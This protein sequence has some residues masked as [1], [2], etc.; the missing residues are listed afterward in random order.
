MAAHRYWRISVSATGDNSG[1]C[2]AEMQLRTT[3]GG[4]TVTGSGTASASSTYSTFVPSQAFDGNTNTAWASFGGPPQSLEYDF[5]VGNAYAIVEVS[6][7]GLSGYT[8]TQAPTAFTID[9]SDNGSSWYSSDGITTSWASEGETQVFDLTWTGSVSVSV[10][11]SV[12]I[13]ESVV[14]ASWT[15]LSINVKE[16][17][18]LVESLSEH[19]SILYQYGAAW[20][21]ALNPGLTFRAVNG[22]LGTFSIAITPPVLSLGGYQQAVLAAQLPGLTFTGVIKDKGSWAIKALIPLLEFVGVVQE[23]NAAPLE[24]A[25]VLAG[26]SFQGHVDLN[27][28]LSIAAEMARLTFAGNI[29]SGFTN[30]TLRY[31]RWI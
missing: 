5:G 23:G 2:I 27:G 18:S 9:Y 20:L 4:G 26:L 14:A 10:V 28:Q 31:Q 12:S 1:V 21:T 13:S 11:D 29:P 22:V 3:I 25:A 16:L 7:T 30:Y 8:E 24:V 19:V 17:V 15:G 6:I